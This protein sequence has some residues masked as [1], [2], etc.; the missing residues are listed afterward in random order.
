MAQAFEV[1]AN[2]TKRQEKT[3]VLIEAFRAILTAGTAEDLIAAVR[4]TANELSPPHEGLELGL[5]EATLKDVRGC[6]SL[7]PDVAVN[8][9]SDSDC[10]Q[11]SLL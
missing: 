9:K 4:L 1:V 3:S 10:E 6:P 8:A 2:T 5:G 7:F 11:T